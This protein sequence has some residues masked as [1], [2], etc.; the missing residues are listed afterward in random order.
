MMPS[1]TPIDSHQENTSSPLA[2]IHSIPRQ[3]WAIVAFAISIRILLAVIT[4]YTSED[5]MITLRYAENMAHGHGLIY[6]QGE[7][8]L[9]TTTP[10]YTLFL[11]LLAWLHL[12]PTLGGKALNIIADGGLCL[13]MYLWLREIGQERAGQIAAFCVGV[14][15]FH[16]QWSISGMETSLVTLCGV[17]VWYAYAAH[18]LC[19][20]YF[21]LGILFLLRWDSILIAPIL[22]AAIIWQER[23]FPAR[24]LGLFALLAALWLIPATLYYGNPIPVTG[25]AKMLVYGWYA[26]HMSDKDV[27]YETTSD[28]QGFTGLIRLEPTPMLRHLPRQQKLLNYFVGSPISLLLFLPAVVGLV[29]VFRS[30]RRALLPSVLWFALYWIVFLFSRVLLFKWYLVPPYPVYEALLALGLVSIG[31]WLVTRFPRLIWRPALAMVL[32]ASAILP[33]IFLEPTLSQAQQ[34][35]ENERIPIGHWLNANSKPTDRVL[36]EPIGYI[37]YYSN[38][39]ILDTIGLVSP[40]VLNFYTAEGRS[41]QIGMLKQY[42]PEWCVLRP[43]ELIQIQEATLVENYAWKENYELI[44]TFAYSPRPKETPL[45]F[46]IF[47]RKTGRRN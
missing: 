31:K 35:E 14:H 19:M 38:R 5:Y 27:R 10:L 39:P 9:G 46:H 29:H 22:T 37:G 8:T 15:P 16:L 23:R 4:R 33:V 34:I 2:F 11:A 47:R 24:E 43:N 21:L 30:H 36:L 41:P 3:V 45:L 28:R 40:D 17:W 25:K 26:D 42:K 20:S 44:K 18:R 32:A 13:V 1:H 6:N 7:R 12:S